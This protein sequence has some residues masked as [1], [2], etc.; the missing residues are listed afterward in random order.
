MIGSKERNGYSTIINIGLLFLILFISC[1]S[2]LEKLQGHWHNI[3]EINNNFCYNTLDF[4][5]SIVILNKYDRQGWYAESKLIF[6]NDSIIIPLNYFMYYGVISFKS[7]T[8]ITSEY[9]GHKIINRKKWLKFN[10]DIEDKESDF[11]SQ[12]RLVVRLEKCND[13]MHIDSI[14]HFYSSIINI[15]RVKERFQRKY[16]SDFYME[17]NNRIFNDYNIIK[18]FILAEKESSQNTTERISV[19]IN[20]D[21]EVPSEILDSIVSRLE[22]TKVVEN[23]YRT[24]IN[25]SKGFIAVKEIRK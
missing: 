11:Q 16:G 15:G 18:S 5:D 6:R 10:N 14:E 1:K 20:S 9:I 13:G 7:D 19:V 23:I 8:L 12:L 21:L 25:E 17:I 3:D 2:D 4:K 22:S 24:C